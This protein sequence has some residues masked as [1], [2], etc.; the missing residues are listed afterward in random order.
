[1]ETV[2][3]VSGS[4]HEAWL[5]T[6]L[7]VRLAQSKF[8]SRF[9]LDRADRAYVREKGM[10]TIRTHAEDLIAKRLAPAVIP[11]DGKQM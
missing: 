7:F 5:K 8:R 1:M 10:D 6:D 4:S 11:N 9:H 3:D 2:E